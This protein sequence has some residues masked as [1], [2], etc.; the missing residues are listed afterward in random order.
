MKKEHL[1]RWQRIA[2]FKL[3]D[4]Q[5]ARPFSKK[6]AEE[7]KWTEHDTL[8]VIAE[9]KKFVFL[10][11]TLPNGASPSPT[12]DEV[13]HL[14][15]TYTDSY[16][17]QFCPHVLETPLHHHP[18]KGGGNETQKHEDW[19]RQTLIGYIE[20]FGHIP[21]NDIW[22]MPLN[23]DPSVYLPKN[24]PFLLQNRGNTDGTSRS[25]H[26]RGYEHT[27]NTVSSEK[28]T[29]GEYIAYAL[30]INLLVAL[31]IPSLLKGVTFLIPFSLLG[32]SI[33][34]LI[35]QH[36]AKHK[37]LIETQLHRLSN[38][39]SPYL[40]AWVSGGNERLLTAFL[41][42]ATSHCTFQPTTNTIVFQLK[43]DENLYKNP[44]YPLL[45][46]L[47]KPEVSIHFI[48]ESVRP[49]WQ[50]IEKQRDE[51][52]YEDKPL[53]PKIWSLIG[54]FYLIG[55]IRSVEGLFFH[56]PILFLL[57]TILVSIITLAVVNSVTS[58]NF[59][60]WR[61]R[62]TN[63]Y[64]TK[65]AVEKDDN[66]MWQF[67][68]GATVFSIGSNW[69]GFENELRPQEEKNNGGDG[70]SSSGCGGSGDG[71]GSSCGGGCGGCC[72]CGS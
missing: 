15:L 42:E 49:Y 14:H 29:L 4:P 53:T 20:T 16:W 23:F 39:F 25:N 47:E 44:L 55:F 6:L 41:Y 17:N 70:G 60:D 1:N 3:D 11:I 5:A 52:G 35:I 18:S 69:Y 66:T 43:H 40:A 37:A 28:T 2:A 21:P 38:C 62:F 63:H 50:L 34:F 32:I 56:K 54:V 22:I 58:L 24:S 8:R 71:G 59:Q 33:A 51:M 45:E 64:K 57:L 68:L 31:L 46:T 19:Y 48:K 13:W 36:H 7:N 10:C 67:A 27:E 12:I 9:Y 61:E 65:Y 72:G 30:I 26:E